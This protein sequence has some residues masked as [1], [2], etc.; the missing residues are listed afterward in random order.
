VV[1]LTVVDNKQSQDTITKT[2]QVRSQNFPPS[3]QFNIISVN[4]LTLTVDASFSTDDTGI[5]LYSWNWGES[6]SS[7]GMR[8]S[9]VYSAYGTYKITL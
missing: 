1:S 7:T 5:Q 2:I 9:H 3:A 6:S 4:D 8:T